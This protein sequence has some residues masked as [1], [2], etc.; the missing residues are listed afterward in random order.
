M[1]KMMI[2]LGLA[3]LLA[4]CSTNG[5]YEPWDEPQQNAQ[6]A[7]GNVAFSAQAN[8]DSIDYNT[9]VKTDTVTLFTA[10]ATASEPI[11]SQRLGVTL[12]SADKTADIT[13]RVKLVK[14]AFDIYLYAIGHDSHWK[15]T[16]ELY[17]ENGD[18]VYEGFAW[19]SQAFKF[20][21]NADNWDDA[22][23][24]VSDGKL[25]QKASD[26]IPVAQDGF[27]QMKVN[28]AEGTYEL[29]RVEQLSLIGNAL[30]G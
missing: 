29:N 17:S 4:A 8:A 7:A 9:N 10:Q 28:L 12:Y 23:G 21:P 13:S 6:E 11:A 15:T 2:A 3:T 14:P 19:L 27:Y 26:N 24:Y 20:R 25:S 22:Y 18:G 5:S 16:H 1:K 30:Q